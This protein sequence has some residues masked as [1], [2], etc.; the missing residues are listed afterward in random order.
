MSRYPRA[1]ATGLTKGGGSPRGVWQG[2]CEGSSAPSWVGAP[3]RTV[4]PRMFRGVRL[5]PTKVRGELCRDPAGPCW[6]GG[7]TFEGR[8]AHPLGVGV[9]PGGGL[10]N[11]TS[12][13]TISPR[14][15]R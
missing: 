10:P 2:T 5:E 1:S 11:W 3:N 15:S 14:M 9:P 6:G 7:R 8:V 13:N 12:R 4:S